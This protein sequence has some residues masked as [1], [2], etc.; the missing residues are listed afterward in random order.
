MER[1]FDACLASDIWYDLA[2]TGADA[3]A[4]SVLKELNSK[5]IIKINGDPDPGRKAVVVDT[6]G[7]GTSLSPKGVGLT[8]GKTVDEAIPVENNDQVGASKVNPKTFV[9]DGLLTNKDTN[10]SRDNGDKIS[11][12]FEVISLRVNANKTVILVSGKNPAKVEAVKADLNNN[13]VKIHQ[14]P[15]ISKSVMDRI[16]RGWS[17]VAAIKNLMNSPALRLFGW[18]RCGITLTAAIIPAVLTNGAKGWIGAQ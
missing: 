2:T 12:A 4:L 1:C 6:H 7:Q 14:K 9:D 17:K 8:V 16:S 15:S 5:I 3:K 18:L 11:K 10:A 13:P